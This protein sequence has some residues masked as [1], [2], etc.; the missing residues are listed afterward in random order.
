MSTTSDDEIE[1][2]DSIIKA[3]KFASSRSFWSWV[4]GVEFGSIPVTKTRIRVKEEDGNHLEDVVVGLVVPNV[5]QPGT[6]QAYRPPSRE[7]LGSRT[8]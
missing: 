7:L 3:S 2:P 1:T 6:G 4:K 5:R 8:S